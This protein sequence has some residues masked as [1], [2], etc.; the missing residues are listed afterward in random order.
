MVYAVELCIFIVAAVLTSALFAYLLFKNVSDAG[1]EFKGTR[2]LIL[3]IAEDILTDGRISPV[4]LIHPD[5]KRLEIVW[6]SL[7]LSF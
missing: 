7:V 6:Q 3:R 5:T 4:R 2:E 1:G